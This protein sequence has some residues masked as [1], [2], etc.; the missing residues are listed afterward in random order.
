MSHILH[1]SD[2][3]AGLSSH[4]HYSEAAASFVSF[5]YIIIFAFAFAFRLTVCEYGVYMSAIFR[6][7]L[8]IHGMFICY[9]CVFSVCCFYCRVS[10]IHQKA[11]N[12]FSR[13]LTFLCLLLLSF[14]FFYILTNCLSTSRCFPVLL[15]EH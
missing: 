9:R 12:S 5:C 11:R 14:F 15:V 7:L 3:V 6:L 1:I 8:G 4:F 10:D 13:E 2:S